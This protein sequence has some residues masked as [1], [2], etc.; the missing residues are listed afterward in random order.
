MDFSYTEQDFF[1]YFNA[2][3]VQW[4]GY[5]LDEVIEREDLSDMLYGKAVMFINKEGIYLRL[6][7]ETKHSG[8]L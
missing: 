5:V 7:T 8:Y 4:L 6:R 3:V 2:A 1:G